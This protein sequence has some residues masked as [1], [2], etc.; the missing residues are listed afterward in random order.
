M[1]KKT[2][3]LITS[4]FNNEVFFERYL[5]QEFSEDF[6][7]IV[8][9]VE[10]DAIVIKDG[11]VM[12]T[13]HAGKN[14]IF[15]KGELKKNPIS[16][17]ELIFIS[18]NAKVQMNWGTGS[19]LDFEDQIYGLPIHIGI[20]GEISVQVG[21]PRKFYTE[22]VGRETIYNLNKLKDRIKGYLLSIIKPAIASYMANQKLSYLYFEQYLTEIANGV[23][24]T[25]KKLFMENFGIAVN[26]LLI[27][28]IVVNEDDKKKIQLRK[29][30]I[31][32]EVKAE[33][34]AQTEREDYL[35]SKEH[36][37]R[38]DLR[39]LDIEEKAVEH[40]AKQKKQK[41]C[42]QCGHHVT[43]DEKFCPE[44]GFKLDLTCKNCGKK[45]PTNAK[46]CPFCGEK[47]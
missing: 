13:I 29:N 42:P 25:I 24:S 14:M 28:G 43:D 8:N 41:E 27:L 15:E 40:Q 4:Q 3:A 2:N 12:D 11:I 26:E 31:E 20:N 6:S 18:K 5:F 33:K 30:D 35:D 39:K 22:I 45:Y 17:L 7:I 44:C 10:E 47:I 38:V 21:N 32:N 37:K 23:S 9:E 1:I 19:P 16:Q 34:K 36:S 46:F